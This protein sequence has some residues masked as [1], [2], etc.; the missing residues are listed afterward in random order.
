MRRFLGILSILVVAAGYASAGNIDDGVLLV[1][2]KPFFPLGSWNSS[3]TSPEDIARLGMNTS[4]RGGPTTDEAV[5]AFREFMRACGKLGVQV[6]PYL[7]YGGAG[8]APWP[9]ENVRR[10]AQLATE[11]NLLT[12][13]VGD[14]IVMDHLPGI[15]QTVN[16]LREQTP[17]IPTVADYIATE[18]PEAKTTFT[19]YV[20]IRCQ[21]AYPVPDEPFTDYLAF[22]DEQRE[23]V[24]DPLWTWLQNFMWGRT[25]RMFN[26]GAEGPGPLPEPE[27]VRLLAYA[28]LLR[29]VRGLLF[30]PHHELHRQPEL[31]ASVA[32]TCREIRLFESHLAAGEMSMNLE[33]SN[34]DVHA[35][36]FRY[37]G[38]TVIA[39]ALLKP[40]YHRYVDEGIAHDV[41]LTCRWEGER[42]P[43]A[44]LVA[45]PDL[46]PCSVAWAQTRGM[47]DVTVP[48]LELAGLILLTN[49]RGE[50]RRLRKQAKAIPGQLRTLVLTG[51][52][53]QARKVSGVVWQLGIDNLYAPPVVM[54]TM[55]A[56]ERC[57]DALDKRDY[58]GAFRAWR[59]TLRS[60]RITFENTMAFAEARRDVVPK[61]LQPFLANPYGL[62][63]VKGLGNAPEAGDPWQFVRS[64]M[65]AGPFPLEWD[66][67]STATPPGF[68]RVYGPEKGGGL[69]QAFD[70]VDGRG[71]WR[72]VET[73]VSALLDFLPYFGTTENV[74]CY[75]RC[76][77]IAPRNVEARVSLGSNDGAR[78][79][80]NGEDVFAWSSVAQGGRAAAPHQDEFPVQLNKGRNRVLAKVEN[81]GRS[82]QLYLSVHDPDRELV[83]EVE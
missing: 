21:Y 39:A 37:G 54:E 11:P 67:E 12:W 22:F 38:S 79:W 61:N 23:F 59:D 74:V 13:Y 3:Y 60:C 66:G 46:V 16:I 25:G 19:Q 57:A 29:G 63:N 15:R 10:I 52:A 6:V 18:T 53:S 35:T 40:F 62:H 30:F 9:P 65:V 73:D 8:V 20:D 2:G 43:E 55:R 33:T 7:S 24:G 70:T 26:I 51:A 42:L 56:V 14:D 77:I 4:F 76:S 75:A 27:Q 71:V 82:W 32:L 69:N 44:M 17:T 64:W 47:V 83:F 72:Y 58:A 36:A 81:L 1:D 49:D 41:T 28:A 34:S 68:D 48:S 78:V 45:A 31:A 50:V 5:A 80:V